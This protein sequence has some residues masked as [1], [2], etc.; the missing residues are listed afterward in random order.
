MFNRWRQENY[1]KYM[2]EEFALDALV[3]Y[4]TEMANPDREVPNPK[5]KAIDKQLNAARAILVKLERQYGAAAFENTEEDRPTMRGFK[6]ANAAEIGKPLGKA[7]EKVRSLEEQRESIPKRVPISEALKEGEKPVQLLMESKRL[8]DTLKMVAYQAES[9]LVNMV[10]PHYRRTEDEG[11]T[12]IATALQ[13]KAELT[14]SEGELRVTLAPQ[15]S[16]HRT[17]AIQAVCDEINKL[18]TKFPGTEMVLRFGVDEA[19]V[20]P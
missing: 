16:A 15:S 12:L 8:S 2:E 6:I 11:R 1:F 3:E 20:W 19:K 18:G 4:G 17:R 5:R 7:R 10:R 13:S 14:I 9:I